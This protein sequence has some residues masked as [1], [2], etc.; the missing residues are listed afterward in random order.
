[1]RAG[2]WIK[3]PSVVSPRS[4]LAE[5]LASPILWARLQHSWVFKDDCLD[6]KSTPAYRRIAFPWITL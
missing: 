4:K 3:R 2:G 6:N 1:M 5:V